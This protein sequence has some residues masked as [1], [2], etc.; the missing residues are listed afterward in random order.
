[1]D[2]KKFKRVR[3]YSEIDLHFIDNI[4]TKIEKA[5]GD[6]ISCILDFWTVWQLNLAYFDKSKLLEFFLDKFG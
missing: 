1:M 2:R 3:E 6:G 4:N 5:M